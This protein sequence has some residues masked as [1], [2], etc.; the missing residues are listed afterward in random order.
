MNRQLTASAAGYL[1][2]AAFVTAQEPVPRELQAMVDAERAFARAAKVK[3]IRDSF[4]EFFA[5]DAIALRPSAVSAKE[6]LR[7]QKPLPAAVQE[8]VW[9]PRTGDLA[10][11]G[12]IGWLTG[13]STFI[14]HGTKDAKP[15]SGNYLSIWRKQADGQWRVFI[16]VGAN[17]PELVSFAPG[18]VRFPFAA[19]Y[20]GRRD[21]A[22]ATASLANADRALNERLPRGAASAY[23][24]LL[25]AAARLHRPGFMTA[26]GPGPVRDWLAAHAGA[27]TATSTTA[28]A[29]TSADWGYSYGLYDLKAET[30]Q[31][32]AYLRIWNRDASGT[33][34]IAA[35]VAQPS[36]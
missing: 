28:E 13:P 34:W 17:T 5:D 6:R 26:V 30:P 35:D 10:A 4:L 18:F 22:E 14:D 23:A 24:P 19:R 31:S 27:M 12:D 29:A 1:L 8:L 20:S 15:S 36:R 25:T 33:W 7:A 21:K 32:G 11:S 3:G 16:D 9:E 2:I